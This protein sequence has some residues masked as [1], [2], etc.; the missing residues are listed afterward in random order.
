MV[1][2]GY[3]VLIFVLML[4]TESQS[5][6]SHNATASPPATVSAL[7]WV[8]GKPEVV[9]DDEIESTYLNPR[10]NP[11]ECHHHGSEPKWLC[12][13]DDVLALDEG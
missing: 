11:K 6:S 1:V 5:D 8:S 12:N 4:C 3:A 7:N 10:K 2:L 13:S 9:S